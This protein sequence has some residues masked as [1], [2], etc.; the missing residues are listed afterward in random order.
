M[1]SLKKKV[2]VSWSSS[3]SIIIEYA[4]HAYASSLVSSLRLPFLP[5]VICPCIFMY[6]PYAPPTS[7]FYSYFFALWISTVFYTLHIG[8]I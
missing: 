8:W 5:I 6:I 1:I 2:S 3:A 4:H 7:Y